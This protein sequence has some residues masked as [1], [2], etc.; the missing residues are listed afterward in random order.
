[1]KKNIFL[2]LL[3]IVMSCVGIIA[4]D[5]VPQPYTWTSQSKNSSESM[6]CG[7]HDVGM[8]VWVE[9][10][11]L[12][13]YLSRSGFFDENNTLLKA[14]RLRLHLTNQAGHPIFS[15][16]A[17]KVD[18]HGGSTPVASAALSLQGERGESRFSQTLCLDDGAI[19]IKGS[20]VEIRLWAD[21]KEPVVFMDVKSAQP[22][23]AT[24]SYET[25][26][27]HDRLVP[28]EA[29]QLFSWKWLT[30]GEHATFADTIRA[31]KDVL[32]FEH[33]NRKQ[34]I[35]DFTVDYE[36]LN[37]VKSEIPDPIGDL[38]FGG[39]LC[40]PGFTYSGT[41]EGTYASTD[42]RA[43]NYTAPS[44]KHSVVSVQLM[45]QKGGLTFAPLALKADVSR[46]RSAQWWH[47]FW[48]RSY[49]KITPRK[50]HLT[51]GN[52]ANKGGTE[53]PERIARNYELFRYMLGCN[54]YG[55]WPTKFNG[56][57]F[58]F[59]PV[60]VQDDN[61]FT[62]DFRCWG[63]GTMTAQNQRLVYW[64]MLKSGD[65]DMMASQFDTYLR[66][67]PAAVARTRH[68]WHHDGASFEEQIENF[69]LPN[70]AEYGKHKDG[71][72]LGWMNNKWLEYQYDT[73]LEFCQMIL[74]AN[75]YTGLNIDKYRELI[76][77][78]V[79]FFDE[80]Y[81]YLAK[82]RGATDLTEDGKLVIYPSAGCETY[83]MAYNP[84]SV[85]AALKCVVGT[86]AEHH[87]GLAA[88]GLDTA[89]ISRIPEIPLR[90]I[91][92]EKCIAP[93][94]TWMRINNVESP[95][96]YPV[97]PWRIYGLGRPDINIAR[98]TYFD[99]DYVQKM[100]SS[101]GWK[102][103]N[104]WAP[105]LGI[106]HDAVRLCSE[107]FENGPYRFPA[108][109]ERGF[110]WAPDHNR[111]GSAMIG[112]QEMLLQETP[113]GELMIFPCW[114][115]DW[116][117]QYRLHA[118]DGRTID[119]S[120]VDGRVTYTVNGKPCQA[121]KNNDNAKGKTTAET[122]SVAS[123]TLSLQG[124]ATGRRASLGNERGESLQGLLI[125]I[126]GDSYSTFE[127][128][129]TPDT[130]EP[131]YY[132]PPSKGKAAGNDVKHPDQTWWWQVIERLGARLE[133]NN[134]YSGS[135]V[136]YT[137]YVNKETGKHDNYKPRSF[138][139]RA[140]NLGNPDLILVCAATNDSWDGEDIGE[141]K[142]ADWTEQ[143]LFTFRPAMARWCSDM[144]RLYPDKRIVF[145]INCD[146]KAD[147]VESMHTILDRYGIEYL[148]LKKIDKQWGH[149]SIKGMKA[150]AD[151]VVEYLTSYSK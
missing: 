70:P 22:V 27:H 147:F 134:S 72:D 5:Y 93:A 149:P 83:K 16:P 84:S 139:T 131:W 113:D 19:Y 133:T 104:I 144:K 75:E 58:T 53:A 109:W 82:Q 106:T 101:R 29:C 87:G 81:R 40:A 9:N 44:L 126:F 39:R 28:R 128:Y 114:P 135:T 51:E 107:K 112:L 3:L 37:N 125:S 151:Q 25:W 24:L 71:Q 122:T 63:G 43:Y 118:S 26:R 127:S 140:P 68:Y 11:D 6:P 46:K 66:M 129:I 115:S 32:T 89:L 7:G 45:S 85:V 132:W 91:N 47:Q 12:L 42:Y 59:D 30:K 73:A 55:E 35:Y 67:L 48:Q 10:G 111:G 34:T 138:I 1:M 119:A 2:T 141:Y 100:R 123:T 86:I 76:T 150:F 41:S 108:F 50:N 17:P 13:I 90:D 60:N 88:W 15:I 31:S 23:K 102:Q 117:C 94:V 146:L 79:R 148:D 21:V 121:T 14:G 77:Q 36:K 18:G 74:L 145:I 142:Y 120:I 64:P 130:N 110:D 61:P 78:T 33:H 4:K 98:N 95:Q 20:R 99:D 49:I 80:H 69:G 54:A 143:D 52:S 92:G 136:G 116:D 8:N 96:L 137:G 38:A 65:V 103:D 56:G 62:P 105:L 124:K 97:F 57:L